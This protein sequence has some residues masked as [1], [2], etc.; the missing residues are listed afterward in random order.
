[1]GRTGRWL[2]LLALSIAGGFF[3]GRVYWT[4]Q[5]PELPPSPVTETL[6]VSRMPEVRLHDL[7][8]RLRDLGEWSSRAL[9]VNFWA[10]WCAPCRKEMPLLEQLHE[11]RAGADFAVIGIAIDREEPVRSFIAETGVSY[12][13][14]VGEEDAMAAAEAFSP[15]FVGLPLT[16]IA[17]PGGEILKVQMGELHAEDLARIVEVLDA[18]AAGQLSLPEARQ[19]LGT[20]RDPAGT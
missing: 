11:Q 8:G 5:K 10:T 4:L 20:D 19:A 7:D 15:Q 16:V 17:A 6:A 13:I 3:T 12:P 1:M 18:L 9:L 2:L 14:L